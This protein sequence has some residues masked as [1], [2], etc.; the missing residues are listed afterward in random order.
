MHSRTKD[1]FL[2]IIYLLNNFY[3]EM[4]LRHKKTD[5]EFSSYQIEL[6]NRVTQNDVT[7]RVTIT[8]MFIEIL[9]SSY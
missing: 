9:L 2:L 3:Q 7:L 6:G 4:F 8:K 5:I 1:L